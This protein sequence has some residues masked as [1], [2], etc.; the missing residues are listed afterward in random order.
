MGLPKASDSYCLQLPRLS[1]TKVFQIYSSQG[2]YLQL[3]K[4][5]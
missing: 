4:V 2:N 3:E 5:D 1:A